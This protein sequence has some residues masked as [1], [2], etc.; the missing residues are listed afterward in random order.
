MNNHNT[1]EKHL[2]SNSTSEDIPNGTLE[3]IPES[4]DEA[5]YEKQSTLF[6]SII[7]KIATTGETSLEWGRLSKII[8]IKLRIVRTNK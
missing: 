8:E 6:D 7:N 5:A 4:F 2:E 3:E 1:E